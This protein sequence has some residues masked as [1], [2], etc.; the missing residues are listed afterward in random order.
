MDLCGKCK[1]QESQR[2]HNGEVRSLL[3]HLRAWTSSEV[4]GARR[5]RLNH[6]LY[7][8]SAFENV[9]VLRVEYEAY[10]EWRCSSSCLKLRHLD[11]GEWSASCP[12][13]FSNVL[14][15]RF[16]CTRLG[17]ILWC[18]FAIVPAI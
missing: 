4:S 5:I 11:G 8:F 7:V 2:Y 6:S 18:L 15:I 9:V 10:G 13:H 12:G 14:H 3:A 16:V 17:G 1:G